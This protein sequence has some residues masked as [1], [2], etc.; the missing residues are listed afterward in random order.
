MSKKSLKK[1]ITYRV[2]KH[3]SV[4][5]G[6]W[7][8]SLEESFRLEEASK[9]QG[10]S[11]IEILESDLDAGRVP[12]AVYEKMNATAKLNDKKFREKE[13]YSIIISPI[14]LVDSGREQR[15]KKLYNPILIPASVSSNGTLAPIGSTPFI[16]RG[17]LEPSS[18]DNFPI[19][20]SLER[21]EKFIAK[22]GGTQF[23]DLSSLLRYA[24]DL[25]KFVTGKTYAK[26]LLPDYEV[27]Q[28]F[29]AGPF[30][31][32]QGSINQLII[33]LD[34]VLRGRRKSN[35]LELVTSTK[36][37]NRTLYKRTK[38]GLYA[39]SKAHIA[40][41][42]SKY[43]LSRSQRRSLNRVLETPQGE[44]IPVSGPPG[45]GKTTLLQNIVA[46]YWTAAALENSK[47]PPVMVV[48]GAT[49][50][51]VLN[52]ISSFDT[53]QCGVE[54]WLPK[55][56][57]Y[58]T[59]CSSFSKAED[60]LM[61]QAEQL[62]GSGF[63]SKTEN[64]SF[65]REAKEVYLRSV[66]SYY[67]KPLT[68]KNAIKT[69]NK[70]LKTEYA[71]LNSRLAVDFGISLKD[72]FFPGFA[73]LSEVEERR[74]LDLLK[75]YD[76]D[77]RHKMFFLA[78]HYWE[79][80]WLLAVEEFLLNNSSQKK[81]HFAISKDDWTRRAMLTPV[82][83]STISMVCKFFGDKETKHIAPIDIL[84][85]DEAGQIPP[86]K[87]VVPLALSNKAIVIGDTK[88]L[89][90]YTSIPELVDQA[91]LVNSKIL[92]G[93]DYSNFKDLARKGISASSSNLMDLAT[94]FCKRDD[95]Q[96]TGAALEEHR[97]SVPEIAQF[98]NILCY[99]NRLKPVR[100]QPNEILFP[101][102]SYLDVKGS[103][104]SIGSSRRNQE[105]A[106]KVY[107]WLK[108]NAK[109]ISEFYKG[110][111]LC[112]IVGCITPFTQQ[113]SYLEGMIRKD[114]PE[115][116]IGT[117]QSI[118]GAE[119]DIVIFSPAYDE[120]F[121]GEYIYDRDERLLN[122]AVS[123]A[124]DSFIV[125]GNKELFRKE[126]SPSGLLGEFLFRKEGN[127]LSLGVKASEY[128]RQFKNGDQLTSL[129]D[130]Q[131]YLRSVLKSAQRR[132]II[133]SPGISYFA[134][135]NDN[136]DELIRETVERGVRVIVCTDNT[137]DIL[138][139]GTLKPQS[140]DGRDLLVRSFAELNVA[141]RI[142]TKALIMDDD[143]IAHS[144]FNWL[145][146]VRTKGSQNQKFETTAV[147]IGEE[148]REGLERTVS[149]LEIRAQSVW[150][151]QG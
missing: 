53:D 2:K 6:Y 137:I 4:L 45:T 12:V 33:T 77:I 10:S 39:N 15:R 61:Y 98:C 95:G 148:A 94:Y 109:R 120:S 107:S 102:F 87:G 122:V 132:V 86:E 80:R 27:I 21:A 92:K 13:S 82:F 147:L 64:P 100:P 106:R 119:R 110:K 149:G 103:S 125:V 81:K 114:W 91:N 40:Q 112:E 41:F 75:Q 56:F 126:G 16:Q 24:E 117:V 133:A 140:R 121:R 58:G 66:S 129:E 115:M 128:V 145:S 113:V 101:A 108:S 139:D 142:H 51:S 99:H 8:D 104:M 73:K 43:P 70:E 68:I 29:H 5:Y 30:S 97:R 111:P 60:V 50:Q 127:S 20:G 74:F 71:Q 34:E 79:A 63:S 138:A 48:C 7:L 141:D 36:A 35:L 52:V 135:K 105:E 118:Q 28:E 25:F 44:I 130:H 84:F 22:H 146:A 134:I 96:I 31:F 143:R 23:K 72:L 88:Q 85:F 1:Q 144:S 9:L 123:R 47:T 93:Y 19:I 57:S 18:D 37:P 83:V 150:R 11:F 55:V 26:F 90:P 131:D 62:D 49:N 69:I 14:S 42:S 65:L 124:R 67:K 76:C 54:R 17:Y 89:S 151:E 32:Q 136:I 38:Y 3:S 59:F 78:T 46:N 116:L